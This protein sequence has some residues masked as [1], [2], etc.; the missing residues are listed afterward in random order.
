[1]CARCCFLFG[2]FSLSVSFHFRQPFYA[3]AVLL[4]TLFT[5]LFSQSELVLSCLASDVIGVKWSDVVVLVVVVVQCH[6]TDRLKVR[7][8]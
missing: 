8:F 1:M 2:V 7:D 6:S 4:F 3:A 5:S